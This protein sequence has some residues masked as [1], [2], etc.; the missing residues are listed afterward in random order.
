MGKTEDYNDVQGK[1][2]KPVKMKG[3]HTSHCC[4]SMSLFY[5]LSDTLFVFIPLSIP[6]SHLVG[7]LLQIYSCCHASVVQHA[8][9][10]KAPCHRYDLSGLGS[11]L[12]HLLPP[13]VWVKQHRY[14]LSFFFKTAVIISQ[15]S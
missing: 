13:A 11:V 4:H 15:F 6:P 8:V 12:C 10:L 7:P 14:F 3:S 1:K 5:C 9:Q 2:K